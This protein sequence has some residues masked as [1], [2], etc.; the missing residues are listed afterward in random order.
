MNL[1]ETAIRP[2]DDGYD[3]A[4]T[5]ITGTAR[6]AIVLHP[7]TTQEVVE[8]IRL[9]RDEGLPLAVRS[10]GHNL[11]NFGNIDDGAVLDL[12]RLD[13]VEV[14]EGDRVRIGAGATWG[15]VAQQLRP[16][17]LAITSGDTVSVGVGGLTQAG[18]IGWMVRKHGLTIDSVVAAEL[19]TAAGEVVGVSATETQTCSGRSGAVPATSESSP[20]SSSRPSA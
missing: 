14:L 5:T 11:L 10:G 17:G 12:S 4:R 19:V 7:R 3:A 6:P 9:A 8:S 16:H 2:G 15:H 20:R 13:T 18:G 1:D